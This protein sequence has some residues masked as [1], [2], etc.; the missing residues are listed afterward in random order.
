MH[1]KS[2]KAKLNPIMDGPF[3]GSPLY[4]VRNTS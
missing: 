4:Q 2:Q 1:S 3:G